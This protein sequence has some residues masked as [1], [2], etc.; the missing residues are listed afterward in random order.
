[1]YTLTERDYLAVHAS[2]IVGTLYW[3][4]VC[5]ANTHCV[6]FFACMHTCTCLQLER[7]LQ[8]READVRSLQ[9]ARAALT[10]Q[11]EKLKLDTDYLRVRAHEIKNKRPKLGYA[12]ALNLTLAPAKS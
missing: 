2:T 12:A 4:D 8:D 9:Q 10:S 7:R 6:M 3:C 5:T 11:L 1:M